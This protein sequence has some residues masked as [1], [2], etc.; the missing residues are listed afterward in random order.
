MYINYARRELILK[1]VYYGPALSGKTTNLIQIH[2]HVDPSHR[3]ELLSLKTTEDRTL[4]FDFLELKLGTIVGLHPRVQLYTVPGQPHYE[5]TRRLVLRGADGVVFVADSQLPRMKDNLESWIA[6]KNHLASYG[7]PLPG[8]P[9]VVQLNK[10][11]LPG[12]V[13]HNLFRRALGLDPDEPV[14]EA[15]ATNGTGVQAPLRSI[16]EEVVSRLRQELAA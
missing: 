1:I 16:L 14:V 12:I 15:V 4:Y 10:R 5:A 2:H 8:L 6:M 13:S 7:I 9:L 3:T 11:D